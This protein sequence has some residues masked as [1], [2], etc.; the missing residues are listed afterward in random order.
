MY[1]KHKI[2]KYIY[3]YFV[4]CKIL[5]KMQNVAVAKNLFSNDM[6]DMVQTLLMLNKFKQIVL[7]QKQQFFKRSIRHPISTRNH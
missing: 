3:M 1:L 2:Q 4:F 5:Y 6:N 7:T